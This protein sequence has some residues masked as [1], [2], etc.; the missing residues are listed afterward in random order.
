VPIDEPALDGSGLY[1]TFSVFQVHNQQS[2][3]VRPSPQVVHPS[4][5]GLFISQATQRP[6]PEMDPAF[7]RV[8][9]CFR[10]GYDYNFPDTPCAECGLLLLPRDVAWVI[11]DP[12]HEYGIS[13]VL[14]VPIVPEDGVAITTSPFANHVRGHP[15]V[16]LTSVYCHSAFFLCT[17]G[18]RNSWRLLLYKQ[19]LGEHNPTTDRGILI[20]YTVRLLAV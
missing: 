19:A 14:S 1:S 3:L 2:R 15:G 7:K 9:K 16:Q 8:Y 20:M 6:I 5:G 10:E 17:S 18:L 4:R 13:E 12:D 11:F